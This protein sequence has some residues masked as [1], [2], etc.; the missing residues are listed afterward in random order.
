MLSSQP[1]GA[2]CPSSDALVTSGKLRLD[3]GS[4]AAQGPSRFLLLNYMYFVIRGRANTASLWNFHP[5]HLAC[6][7]RVGLKVC[8]GIAFRGRQSFTLTATT[9]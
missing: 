6:A 1:P 2:T 7:R 5:G 4:P 9:Y 8:H 3:V